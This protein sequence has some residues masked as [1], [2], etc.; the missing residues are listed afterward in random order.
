MPGT[1]LTADEC[2]RDTE[3]CMQT[4]NGHSLQDARN[5]ITVLGMRSYTEIK[6][7]DNYY[8]SKKQRH[9][10]VDI[11]EKCVGDFEK[12][13]L[14][15]LK[16]PTSFSCEIIDKATKGS[17]T[18]EDLLIQTILPRDDADLKAIQTKFQLMYSKTLSSVCDSELSG[19][20][21][22]LF[23]TVL[24][25][26]SISGDVNAHV[27]ALYRA[28]EGKIGTDEKAFIDILGNHSREHV[29]AVATVYE[30]KH[31]KS[32][33]AVVKSEFGGHLQH[34]LLALVLPN[35]NY[36]ATRLLKALD[37]SNTD[38]DTVTRICVAQ[39]EV[40][41]TQIS[42][43]M[44]AINAPRGNELTVWVAQK[45]GGNYGALLNAICAAWIDSAR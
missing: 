36:Y 37:A 17:G 26:R 42:R 32:L 11:K 24:D 27:A 13:C 23:K 25:G 21:K 8:H 29:Q 31:G 43:A 44:A 1:A 41:L 45:T 14:A 10:D 6:Q 2:D 3:L 22:T 35:A 34:A 7:I 38:E 33:A 15:L 9:L 16:E 40:N 5:L 28:G 30:Q 20:L 39:R 19:N 12:L 4:L 18:D